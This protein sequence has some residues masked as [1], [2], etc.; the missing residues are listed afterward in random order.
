[1]KVRAPALRVH[2]IVSEA[3]GNKQLFYFVLEVYAGVLWGRIRVFLRNLKLE[4][5]L[6]IK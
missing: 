2:Y 4:L 3:D 6:N 1:M 5:N